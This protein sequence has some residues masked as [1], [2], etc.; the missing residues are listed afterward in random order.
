[1]PC[2]VM[3]SALEQPCE[4][5]PGIELTGTISVLMSGKL[6]NISQP[7]MVLVGFGLLSTTVFG[8]LISQTTVLRGFG[9]Y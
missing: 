3:F 2:N 5:Q 9:V 4:Q 6:E 7:I 1:M 8:C